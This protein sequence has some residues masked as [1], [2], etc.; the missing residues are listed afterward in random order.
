MLFADDGNLGEMEPIHQMG[1]GDPWEPGGDGSHNEAS[2]PA[3]L[4][5]LRIQLG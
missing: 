4:T 2:A 3:L 5:G 1:Q